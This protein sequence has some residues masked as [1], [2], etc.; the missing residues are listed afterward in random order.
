MPPKFDKSD[1]QSPTIAELRA[2]GI[3]MKTSP[4]KLDLM[5]YCPLDGRCPHCGSSLI[6]ANSV[7]K[8]KLCYATPWPVSIVGIDMR[9]T[10]CKKHFMTHD[11]RYVDTLPLAEQVMREFVS[12]KGNGSHV[13]I[14]RLLRLGMTVAQVERYVEEEVREHYLSLKSKYIALWDKVC[15]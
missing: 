9:C 11:P 3:G 6:L 10:K 2:I 12:T 8:R 1:F 15:I 7:G 5:V 4:G 14:I 13:A